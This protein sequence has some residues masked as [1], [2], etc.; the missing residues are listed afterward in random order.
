MEHFLLGNITWDALPHAWYTIGATASIALMGIAGAAL[1]TYYKRWKWLWKEWLTSTDPK[2]IGIMYIVVA[3]VMFFRGGLDAIMIWIQQAISTGSSQ[4]YLDASHFQQIFTA[5]GDIMVFF[6]TMGFLFGLINLILP[7]QIGARDLAF[8]F[9]NS[10]GFWLYVAGAIFIN[11]F[12]VIGGQFAAAGWLSL[13]PLSEIAYSPG[14]GVDYWIW[15]LQISGLGSLLGGIN[16]VVTILKMRV[17]G[18]T[19]MKMPLFA[20][21]SL[22]SMFLVIA[23]FPVLTATIGLLWLDRFFGMHFFTSGFGGNPMM[24]V[25]LIWMWGHPEVYILVI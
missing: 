20:W 15:S 22:C 19:L 6:V 21:T 16:F 7:L 9:L 23:A 8:P 10:L 13:P 11:M 5:H 25:N 14:T 18:M 4:G 1:I 2:K 3:S 24:Y 12:F 17:K